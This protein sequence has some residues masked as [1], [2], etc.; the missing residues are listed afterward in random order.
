MSVRDVVLG[1][2]VT[3]E[4]LSPVTSPPV[5]I[6]YFVWSMEFPHIMLCSSAVMVRDFLFIVTVLEPLTVS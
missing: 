1:V 6:V 2:M 4:I 5:G 3:F